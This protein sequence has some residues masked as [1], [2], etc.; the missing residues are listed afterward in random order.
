MS[1]KKCSKC[2]SCLMPFSKDP[3]KRESEKYCSY[4]FKDGKLCAEGVSLKE[5]QKICY[6]A[7][8][9]HGTNKYMAKLYT[10]M[11]K[12]APRWKK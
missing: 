1:D 12:F 4:C 8:V 9:G 7:M 6:D 5:F 2:E 3:G 10:Y 11:I